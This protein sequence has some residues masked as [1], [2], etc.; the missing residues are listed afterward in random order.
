M[1]IPIGF[2]FL[3]LFSVFISGC[4]SVEEKTASVNQEGLTLS[5]KHIAK[6]D[7]LQQAGKLRPA[8]ENYQLAL[9][10][11]P[12]N[13]KALRKKLKIEKRL[14]NLA[15]AHYQAGQK[16]ERENRP[17]PAKKEYI[18]ALEKWPDHE[19][20]KKALTRNNYQ[21]V[22]PGSRYIIHEIMPGESVSKLAMIYYD[23]YKKYDVIGGFNELDDMTKVY[24]GQKIRI[25]E[26]DSFEIN[27]L[28]LKKQ[29]YL[30]K[31]HSKESQLELKEKS[32]LIQTESIP[33][34]Q[35]IK[36]KETEPAKTIEH[37]TEPEPPTESEQSIKQDVKAEFLE[38]E[39]KT[40]E[41]K[42]QTEVTVKEKAVTA[43][44]SQN[45]TVKEKKQDEDKAVKDKESDEI[46]VTASEKTGPPLPVDVEMEVNKERQGSHGPDSEKNKAENNLLK[47]EV[48][49]DLTTDLQKEEAEAETESLIKSGIAFFN[50]KD[51]T[52]AIAALDTAFSQD[53]END[54][55]RDYLFKSYFQNGLDLF[56]NK[57]YLKARDSFKTAKKYKK[58]CERCDKLIRESER[59]YKEFHYSM[60]THYFGKEQLKKAI[61]EWQLV[62]DLEPEYKDIKTKLEKAQLLYKRL[63]EIK[64][65]A[66]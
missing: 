30:D 20:A 5:E 23:D 27:A 1:K 38:N 61:M 19:K 37:L 31:A 32:E 54:T 42:T 39:K 36:P 24:V 4:V 59:R 41:S 11:D 45:K 29:A 50:K 14:K 46:R 6:G 2:I 25:P 9:T 15:E 7:S 58:I 18:A 34:E 12:D 52:Q 3:I 57:A 17:E 65:G 22:K 13:K 44:E 33:S 48:K 63:E 53:P 10:F 35:E 28:K 40:L 8:L 49:Q 64:K 16:Y 60:G 62:H 55:I 26:L 66:S 51:Y 43:V 56:N 21:Q 47:A